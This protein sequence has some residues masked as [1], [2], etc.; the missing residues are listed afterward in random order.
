MF[1]RPT[2]A[3]DVE[4]VTSCSEGRKTQTGERGLSCFD[5]CFFCGFR[6]FELF[7]KFFIYFVFVSVTIE[8]VAL[9][10]RCKVL[11]FPYF[12]LKRFFFLFFGG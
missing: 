7:C 12:R 6:E 11:S 9:E 2:G 1:A 8:V 5:P 10:W 3:G 4:G